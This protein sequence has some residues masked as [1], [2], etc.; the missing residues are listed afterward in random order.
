MSAFVTF[1]ETIYQKYL[2]S[3][4]Y[5][6]IIYPTVNLGIKNKFVYTE[7]SNYLPKYNLSK[8]SKHIFY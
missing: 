5:S 7:K 3:F 8:T 2:F 4:F 1:A 6:N